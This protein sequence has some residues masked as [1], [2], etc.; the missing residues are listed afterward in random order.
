MTDSANTQG[1]AGLAVPR[2]ILGFE[3]DAA[4]EWIVHLDCGHRRHVRHRPPLSEYPWLADA[5]ARAARV[6]ASIE[7][8]RCGRGELPD[9]A[10][11]YRTTE[12]FDETN[13]PAGLRRAHTIR[14]GAW[15][16]V[17]VLAGRLRF[18]MPALAVDR[19]LTAGEQAIIPPELPH[20][21]EPL[22][23]V[24]MQVVFLRVPPG[25]LPHGS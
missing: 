3:R 6:G 10:A 21:V 7:C 20:H 5:A 1:G 12:L 9:G 15:G 19:V 24:R 16:R 8:G 4:D 22:G 23:P 13:L 2:R 25:D 18:V 17:E 14:A 11:A